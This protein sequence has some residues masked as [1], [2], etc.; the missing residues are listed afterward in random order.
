MAVPFEQPLLVI[1]LNK[2]ADDLSRLV[3]C[4]EVVQVEALLFQRPQEPK[5]V[6]GGPRDR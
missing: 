2:L 1:P 4:G 6:Q 3:Q 5:T